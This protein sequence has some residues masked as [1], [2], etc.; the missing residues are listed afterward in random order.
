MFHCHKQNGCVCRGW[1]DTHGNQGEGRDLISLRMASSIDMSEI[2]KAIKEGPQVP[3]FESGA[4]ACA[5]GLRDIDNP[6]KAAVAVG[7]MVTKIHER[8]AEKSGK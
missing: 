7:E 6:S 2:A 4:E 3:V 1:I 5:H 8:K